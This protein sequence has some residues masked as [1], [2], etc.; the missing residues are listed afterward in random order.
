MDTDEGTQFLL[1]ALQ[2]HP[3]LGVVCPHIGVDILKRI[4]VI[5]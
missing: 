4:P 2:H 3:P 1:V 5:A